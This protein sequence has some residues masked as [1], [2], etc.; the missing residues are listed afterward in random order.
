MRGAWLLACT[1]C[2]TASPP[3]ATSPPPTIGTCTIRDTNVESIQWVNLSVRGHQFAYFDGPYARLDVEI[4][5]T[6]A[7]AR[8]ET[9]QVELDGE[10]RLDDFPLRPAR[11]TLHDGWVEIEVATGR[12]A[13]GDTLRIDV[14]LPTGVQP[15]S[16]QFVVPCRELTFA[17][18][19]TDEDEDES[20]ETEPAESVEFLP[21]TTTSLHRAPGEPA[22]ARV[23][24]PEEAEHDPHE[25]PIDEP[26]TARVLERRGRIVRVRIEGPNAVVGWVAASA[27]RE[28]KFGS[29]YGIGGFGRSGVGKPNALQCPRALPIY[30]RPGVGAEVT[31]VG[32]LKPN[33]SVL[34]T[35]DRDGAEVTID[36]GHHD[37]APFVRRSDIERACAP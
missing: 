20:D 12:A 24:A 13:A 2:W 19:P 35:S 4:V 25:P 17:R 21:A 32:T 23:V 36:L 29:L 10:L 6:R 11:R 30:V 18:A 14:A 28:P 34:I 9:A 1:G 3:P 33:A 22:V 8:V 7:R 15:A 31:R 5:G 27:V 26:V 37:V 16:K